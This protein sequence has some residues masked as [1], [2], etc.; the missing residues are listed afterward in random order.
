MIDKL[1]MPFFKISIV[2]MFVSEIIAPITTSIGPRWMR[3]SS[4][5]VLLSLQVGIWVCGNYG[6]FNFLTASITLIFFETESIKLTNIYDAFFSFDLNSFFLVFWFI[7]SVLQFPFCTF[8]CFVWMYRFKKKKLTF[9]S[10]NSPRNFFSSILHFL[11]YFYRFFLPLRIINSYGVFGVESSNEKRSIRLVTTIEGFD[12]E[13]W[14]QF[15]MKYLTCTE[16]NP[17]KIFAPHHPRVDMMMWYLARGISGASF[18]NVN[19]FISSCAWFDRFLYLI[20]KKDPDAVSLF[21]NFPF[22]HHEPIRVLRVRKLALRFTTLEEYLQ[23]G[24]YFVFLSSIPLYQCHP[25]EQMFFLKKP[26]QIPSSFWRSKLKYY[27]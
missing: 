22:D 5:Y 15:E 14:R 27:N 16:E 20:Y 26:K 7:G 17:P 12:G 18:A 23:T 2:I 8:T 25:N 11:V 21:K 1:P 13:Y 19:P 4:I 24:K 9:S 10:F 6:I 3:I